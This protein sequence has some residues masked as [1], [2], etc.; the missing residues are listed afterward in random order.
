MYIYTASHGP[1]I[2]YVKRSTLFIRMEAAR[3]LG[4]L[5]ANATYA[6]EILKCDPVEKL[7]SMFG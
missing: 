1:K 7:Q 3:C 2:F 5:A 4:N 6:T